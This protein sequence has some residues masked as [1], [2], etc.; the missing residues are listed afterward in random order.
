MCSVNRTLNLIAASFLALFFGTGVQAQPSAPAITQ[1]FAF[2][3]SSSGEVC[4]D[5]RLP[6]SLI[7]SADGNFYG[8]TLLGG[9][10]NGANG[11][12]VFKITSAGQF[13]LLY[14][15]VADANGN[16]S[17]GNQPTALVEG[18]DG[19]LYGTTIMGGPNNTGLVFKL[20]KTGNFQI[21]NSD[22]GY[23]GFGPITLVVGRNG[24]LYGGTA[25]NNTS[26]S[27]GSLF[28]VTPGGVYTLLHALS[29]DVEGP[30]TLGMTL[31]S[32]GNFYGTTLGA[33][34]A[35]TVFYRLTPS[36]EFTTL[37]TL[38]YAQ[39]AESSPIQASNGLLY[40]GLSRYEDDPET[41]MF[42]SDLSGRDFE[43]IPLPQLTTGFASYLTSASDSNLWCLGGIVTDKAMSISLDGAL[44]QTIP[45]DGTNFEAP[46]APLVQS[47]N[48]RFFGVAQL[49]GSAPQGEVASGGV[50]TLDAGLAPPK[51]EL[52]AFNPSLG[53]LG[54]Q[55]AI[56]GTH[57]V[58]TT[59]V[60]FNGVS[61]KFTVFSTGYILAT[62]P[63]GATTGPIRV[64]N[65]GGTTVSQEDFAVK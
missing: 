6:N 40:A 47:S 32:D 18:N 33:T 61:A 13:T 8:T 10:G 4:A 3:C 43:Q 14:T 38:V 16:Y 55:V 34:E 11:G 15:F 65:P 9:P 35:L 51:A 54:A 37:Q 53:N 48:G 57:F 1:L 41:G 5:G 58:G 22:V 28:R 46:D 7:Q 21:L 25:G 26:A 23:K 2:A 29:P 12:T 42:S 20:S 63:P 49:G 39:F 31:A 59:A 24:D 30:Q 60:T 56:Y 17:H 52:V 19:F 44:L 50:F 36:G 45:F 62:V 27:G 64:T